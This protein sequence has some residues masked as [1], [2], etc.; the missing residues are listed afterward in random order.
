[1]TVQTVARSTRAA[2]AVVD[3]VIAAATREVL[4]SGPDVVFRRID[5]E[6]LRRGVRYRALLPRTSL[7]VHELTS[8]G[9]DVRTVPEVPVPALVIDGTAVMLPGE[10]GPVL[11]R[12]PS[13]VRTTVELFE[14]LWRTATPVTGDE[15]DF[16]EADLLTLL[17]AGCTDES[18]AIRLGVS[19]RTVRRMVADIMRRLGARSRFQAGV[20]AMGR[21]WVNA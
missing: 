9:A 7:R 3:S 14:R 6:N 15:L 13:V 12:L 2:H 1:M 8:C 17:S 4:V 19:V 20:K 5:R 16:R 10:D 18:I 21:G 11:F